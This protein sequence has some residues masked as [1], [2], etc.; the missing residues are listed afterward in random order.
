[1]NKTEF[2]VSIAD[3]TG[4]SRRQADKSV[5]AM[6][7]VIR[8]ALERGDKVQIPGFGTFYVNE[9][10]AREGRN[11]RTGEVITIAAAKVPDFKASKVLKAA[12]TGTEEE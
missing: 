12:V 7:D 10:A 2:T 5:A 6:I 3:R 8:E 11:P 4:V 9:R 1:M